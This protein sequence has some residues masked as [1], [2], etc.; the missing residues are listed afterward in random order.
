MA[1]LEARVYSRMTN[2]LMARG[3]IDSLM[4][5]HPRDAT[6]IARAAAILADYQCYSDAFR[7]TDRQLQLDPKDTIALVN[8]GDFC[9]LIGDYSNAI[10]PLTLALS[11]TNSPVARYLRALAYSRTGSLDAAEADYQEILRASPNAYSAYAGLSE[12]AER[13]KD[14]KAA[15]RYCEQY[16]SGAR[17]GTEEARTVAARLKSLQQAQIGR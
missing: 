17:A 5:E 3:I 8:K 10:P 6:V 14:T 12:I 1:F 13:R 16:L 11:L 9:V 15:V 2:R 4:F 7:I